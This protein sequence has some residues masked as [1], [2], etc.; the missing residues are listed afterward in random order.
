M[1]TVSCVEKVDSLIEEYR[2]EFVLSIAAHARI[3]SGICHQFIDFADI[4]NPTSRNI[5]YAATRTHIQLIRSLPSENTLIHC[6]Q[7]HRRSPSAAFILLDAIFP[8]K[9]KLIYGEIV[10]LAPYVDFNRHMLALANINILSRPRTLPP[11]GCYF[12][13]DNEAFERRSN[14]Y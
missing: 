10:R 14:K 5:E 7:G 12:R 9:Q 3:P 2:P 13:F 11:K 8:N 6:K 4:D 1:I